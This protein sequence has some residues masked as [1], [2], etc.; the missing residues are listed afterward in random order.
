[1]HGQWQFVTS[2]AATRTTTDK[3]LESTTN[4]LLVPGIAIASVP[5]NFL[6][7]AQ[8]SRDL[9]AELIGSH[10]AL[11]SDA[12]F[13]RLLV[14]SEHTFDL[15]LKWH[16]QLR[17]EVGASLVSDFSEL[18]GIYRFFAGGDRSVRGFAYNS[19]SPEEL[20]TDSDGTTSLKKTGGRYLV[21]GS[22]EI[23]RDL[24]WNLAVAT[25][26]DF[27]NAFNDAH[28]PLEYAAG[29]GVRY[30]LPG[31]SVGIDVAKPL[32]VPNGKLRLHLNITPKL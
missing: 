13:L 6:G 29:V 3:G 19:L 30:R 22:T 9:Y 5:K 16:L 17:G 31:V 21:V 20:V 1:V 4:K 26:F 18:P 7:E 23:V 11:G 2:V 32:S 25:F 14:Q 8:F 12:N 15:S 10:S 24:P 27:G 28:T